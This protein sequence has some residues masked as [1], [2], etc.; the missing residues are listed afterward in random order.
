MW[1]YGIVVLTHFSGGIMV[2]VF[3]KNCSITVLKLLWY[4]VLTIFVMVN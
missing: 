3:G 2:I 1:T 4:T